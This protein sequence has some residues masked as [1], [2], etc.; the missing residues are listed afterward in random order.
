MADIPGFWKGGPHEPIAVE[1]AWREFVRSVGGSVVDELVGKQP[2]FENADFVFLQ[3]GVVAE[4]K[5]IETEFSNSEAFK[6]R[7]QTLVEDIKNEQGDSKASPTD[8]EN[9]LS[10]QMQ[11]RF[12]RL[13]RPQLARILKKAN[14][15]I[16][17][18]KASFGI[19]SNTGVL[20]LVNDGFTSLSPLLIRAQVS[21]L[22]VHSYTS[23]DCCIYLTVNRYVALRDSPQPVLLWA[24][25]YSD[26]DPEWLLE[27]VN[28]LGRD[29][30]AYLERTI[31]PFT[32]PI[33]QSENDVPLQ[34]SQSILLPGENDG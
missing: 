3:N 14:R 30:F 27:F 13:F 9:R 7:F 23:I 22:L 31:G 32:S 15:Q 8:S 12:V 19:A 33:R 6:N 20:L 28:Q 2:A 17:E 1:P 25:V 21:E 10:G 11:S 29:W 4:L 24:P 18:T 34:G 26:R 5:E 16:R